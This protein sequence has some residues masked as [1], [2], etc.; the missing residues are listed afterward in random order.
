[1]AQLVRVSK[2]ESLK[3]PSEKF[4]GQSDVKMKE[5]V[6]VGPRIRKILKN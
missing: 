3:C 4:L 5:G 6:F 2:K 1:M